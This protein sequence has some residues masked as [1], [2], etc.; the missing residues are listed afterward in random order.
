MDSFPQP[1]V[2]DDRPVT[3]WHLIPDHRP[4]TPEE[5]GRVLSQLHSL[6]LP[7]EFRLPT[8]EPFAGLQ[9]R[10]QSSTTT[11]EDSRSWL[12]DH[13]RKLQRKHDELTESAA[14][15]V[16]HGD[17]W[18]GNLVVPRSGCCPIVLDLDNVSSCDGLALRS[19]GKP[20]SS[21]RG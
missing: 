7:T 6:T 18:Q 15:C 19:A 21:D 9:E 1:T 17:A 3:W 5:L 13:Y 14:P 16:I 11:G 8:Y 4:S 12:L 20:D 10:I 2:V